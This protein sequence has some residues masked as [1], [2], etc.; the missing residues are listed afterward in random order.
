ML[1]E[2]LA[3]IGTGTTCPVVV[4]RRDGTFLTG[5]RNYTPDKYKA[6]SV[7]TVPGGRCDEGETVETTLRREVAEE[8]GIT[9]LTLDAFW[10]EVAGAKDGDRVYVFG[11]RTAQEATLMEP[12]KF[13]AWRW[14]APSELPGEFINPAVLALIGEK[15]SDASP[16]RDAGDY[17]RNEKG[18]D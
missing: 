15:L 2:K 6:V 4:I 12:E 14:L 16:G 9:D 1:E 13:S 11:G 10:G 3:E 8:T 5:L 18:A 7:W 17:V